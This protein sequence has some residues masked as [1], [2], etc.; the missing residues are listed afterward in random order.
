MPYKT[1]RDLISVAVNASLVKSLLR[2]DQVVVLGFQAG[3]YMAFGSILA[4]TVSAMKPYPEDDLAALDR[5]P[6]ATLL[7]YAGVFPVGLIAVVVVG[8]ELFTSNIGYMISGYLRGTVTLRDL[9]KNWTLSYLGNF[10][11][12]VFAAYFLA[13]Q[14]DLFE[15]EPYRAHAI[16]LAE[17]KMSHS[18]GA[19]F[20]RGVG[21]NWL[22]GGV[23]VWQS[24]AADDIVGKVLGIWWPVFSFMALGYEHC[25][26][27]MYFCLIGLMLGSN[28]TFGDFLAY[29]L[30]PVTLGNIVGGGLF[31]AG[32]F[33][34]LYL[35]EPPW[36]K[37]QG[38]QKPDGGDAEVANAPPTF[39]VKDYSE[40]DG[41]FCHVGVIPYKHEGSANTV[42]RT[43]L[44][45]VK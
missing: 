24:L 28:K 30:V 4:T 45:T 11:G 33:W 14:A 19:A 36:T 3:V 12:A 37:Q 38:Q 44:E 26:A 39:H 8:G 29:N 41:N 35:F 20:L 13:F 16:N 25:I 10:L 17:V 1:P 27:D 9:A 21:G 7:A 6:G 23:A 32:F 40:V 15:S 18:W 5:W 22:S 42:T 43:F 2:W 34:Y 31:I